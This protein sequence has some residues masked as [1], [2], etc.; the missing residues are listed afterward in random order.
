MDVNGISIAANDFSNSLFSY[1]A[2]PLNFGSDTDST[3]TL[4]FSFP[5]VGKLQLI[6]RHALFPSGELMLGSSNGFVVRPFA[7]DVTVAGNPAATDPSGGVLATA[8]TPFT[9]TVRAVLWDSADDSNND[10]QADGHGDTDPAN[11]TNLAN[12]TAALNFGQEAPGGE[13]VR[14]GADLVLPVGGNSPALS[15]ATVAAGYSSGIASTTN[16]RFDEVGVIELRTEINDGN[17]LDLDTP[18]TTKIWG[19]SSYVGRFTPAAFGVAMNTP[20]FGTTCGLGGFSYL[21]DTFTYTTAPVITVTALNA[22]GA[23]TQNYTG[24]WIKMT[25]TDLSGRTYVAET[26]TLDVSGLPG[27]GADP[28]I[29]DTGSGT[30]GLTFDAGTGLLFQRGDPVA[31]FNAE[32]ELQINVADADGITFGSNPARVGQATAGLGIGFDAGKTTRWGRL[33]F[34][35]A[36]GSELVDLPV[37]LHTE[38]YDGVSWVRNTNDTCTTLTTTDLNMTPVPG[39]LV[40]TPA[41]GNAPLA[42]GDA[43]LSLSAPGLGNVGRFDLEFDI[44]GTGANLPF[45]FYDWDDDT[46]HDDNPNARASFGLYSGRPALIYVRELY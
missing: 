33:A 16:L 39:G 42:A 26:G 34:E 18:E 43:D 11:N 10:G 2:L 19:R 6:A 9:A 21:G 20:Q 31:P 5:D 13:S 17:Y 27:T 7:M 8:G 3:A 36:Y 22:S 46:S 41:I 24:S 35:N 4:A 38:Y 15:G 29:A 32:I 45:L 37:P 14:I 25:N 30:V 44:S 12:N 40:S 1:A 28:S 23:T